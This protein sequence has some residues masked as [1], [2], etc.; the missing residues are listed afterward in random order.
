VQDTVE[1]RFVQDEAYMCPLGPSWGRRMGRPDCRN[2]TLFSVK[3][4]CYHNSTLEP[5]WQGI[6]TRGLTRV[7]YTVLVAVNVVGRSGAQ[8][9]RESS[10]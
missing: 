5:R 10:G 2:E 8:G 9:R 1:D 6:F 4:L 3:T 7:R